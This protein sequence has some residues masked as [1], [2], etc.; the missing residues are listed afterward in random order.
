[1]NI[2][3]VKI[4][5]KKNVEACKILV[6]NSVD[7]FKSDIMPISSTT[8]VI[9]SLIAI[10]TS[11]PTSRTSSSFG[12]SAFSFTAMNK[13]IVDKLKGSV[14]AWS[15]KDKQ[16]GCLLVMP[17]EIELNYLVLLVSLHILIFCGCLSALLIKDFF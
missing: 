15:V 9:S 1:M 14:L 10:S 7:D 6:E 3:V 8:S 12:A 17:V 13:S 4:P 2:E 16:V 11:L 5:R